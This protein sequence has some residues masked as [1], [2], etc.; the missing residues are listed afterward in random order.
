MNPSTRRALLAAILGTAV[1]AAHAQQTVRL[2][3]IQELSG[4]GATAG[5]NAKNGIELAV[6]EINA[7]GGI[8]GRKLETLVNDTQSNPGV[9][10]G[11]ATKAVDDD[12]FAVFGPTFSG[13]VLV[14]MA[15]TRRAEVPNFTGGEASSITQQGNPYIFRTS[16]T[17]AS[18]MPKVARYIATTLKAKTVAVMF[19]NNDFGK[20]GRDAFV[21]SAEAAGLKVAADIST[22]SGQ[23]DFAAPVLRAKQSNADLLFVYTNEEES[24]RALRELRKQGWSKPVIGETTL[25]GQKVIDL[26]GEA[27]NGAIAHVGLTVDAPTP[28][29]RS[30]RAKF[31]K[32]YKY[33]SDHNGI[34][35]YTSVY[36]LKAAIEKVGKFDRVAVAKALHG[37]SIA[38]AK[39]PGVLMDVS[40]DA[41]GDLDRESFIVEVKNGKQEV[42]ETLPALGKK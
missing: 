9:A 30:F 14:S 40:I 21:K 36:M 23:V 22:E 10:K 16:F 28:A 6:K 33:V 27:A 15:E 20:G 17:Q 29:M 2:A 18:S 35:G 39:E 37:L 34:K 19:V 11:L 25:T 12:V 24:A 1:L 41:N 13:S 4:T 31:E 3:V 26:A 5:T 32:E 38:V 7:A 42:R 8:L